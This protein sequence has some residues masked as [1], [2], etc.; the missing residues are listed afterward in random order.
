MTP[1]IEI[2]SDTQPHPHEYGDCPGGCQEILTVEEKLEAFHALLDAHIV[3]ARETD[4]ALQDLKET[5]LAVQ[6]FLKVMSAGGKFF[7]W[8][9]AILA[10]VVAIVYTVKSG[11]HP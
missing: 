3:G 8:L 7:A 5:M 2:F 11:N 4:K 1:P 6:G 10:P 9:F